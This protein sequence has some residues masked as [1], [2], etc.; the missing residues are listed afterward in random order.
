ME[1]QIAMLEGAERRASMCDTLLISRG[2]GC[3]ATA[4]EGATRRANAFVAR[5]IDELM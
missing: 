4:F 2:P 1:G 5:R 3:P